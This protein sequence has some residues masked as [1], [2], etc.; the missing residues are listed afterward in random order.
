MDTVRWRLKD[1]LQEHDLTEEA[2]VRAS[3]LS[4]RLV[5]ALTL[6][7]AEQ[8]QL[9]TLAGLLGGL[10]TLTG[11]EV[12]LSDVLIYVADDEVND[13]IDDETD[14]LLASG[15]VDLQEHL[16]DLEQDVPPGEMDAWLRAFYT[17]A[18]KSAE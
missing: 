6:E 4:P 16:D 5:H 12:A 2:L 11:T 17:A 13:E 9:E 3:N 18:S 10:R 8:V 14:A 7:E 15:T 1:Y